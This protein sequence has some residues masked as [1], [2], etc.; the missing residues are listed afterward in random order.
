MEGDKKTNLHWNGIE[1][2]A[3]GLLVSYEVKTAATIIACDS[4]K[5]NVT[6]VNKHGNGSGKNKYR[7]E[8]GSFTKK[9]SLRIVAQVQPVFK[10]NK[11]GLAVEVVKDIQCQRQSFD[12][13]FDK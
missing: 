13:R 8:M 10:N 1:R 11:R 7:F 2:V 6:T 5:T 9:H 12:S 3:N 4:T